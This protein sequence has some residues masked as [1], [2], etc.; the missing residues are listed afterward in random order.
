MI[1]VGLVGEDP[2]DTS[3]I[4]LLLTKKYKSRV[5]FCQLL[6]GTKGHQLDNQKTK[7]AV[8]VEIRTNKCDLTLF[9]RD[10]DGFI[11]QE[12]LVAQKTAWFESLNRV[13]GGHNLFLLN[14]WELEALIFGDIITFN[15]CYGTTLKG[16]S[17]PMMIKNPK[18]ELKRATYKSKRRYEESHCPEIFEKLDFNKVEAKCSLFKKFIHQFDERIA[19]MS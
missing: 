4:K 1:R 13:S 12:Q 3:S 15:N 19:E 10:L 5:H 2:N 7:K 11:S 9:I 17:D 8:S 18:E 16:N 14:T 6:K